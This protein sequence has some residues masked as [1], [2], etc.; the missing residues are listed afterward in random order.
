MNS[1]GSE[2]WRI[3]FAVIRNQVKQKERKRQKA[4]SSEHT[5]SQQQQT[6]ETAHKS[7]REYN[8]GSSHRQENHSHYEQSD[9]RKNS[10]QR[11]TACGINL[12]AYYRIFGLTPETLTPQSI[13]KAYR[14]LCL[15][16]HPDRNRQ[17]DA[18]AKFDKVQRVY[19]VLQKELARK[20]S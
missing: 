10:Y 1:G 11:K 13:K 19:V 15:K 4:Y 17:P 3:E 6:E 5:Q 18:A 2:E 14:D 12:D 16:Y 7:Q 20:C 9:Y 8:Q